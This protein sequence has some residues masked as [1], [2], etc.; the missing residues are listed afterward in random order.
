MPEGPSV[1]ALPGKGKSFEQFRYDDTECRSFA[2]EQTGATTAKDA[3]IESGF[4][5]AVIGAA[6]GAIAGFVLGGGEGAAVGAGT[7]FLAGGL[8]GTDNA[9][10]SGF[11]HQQRYDQGYIQCMYAKGHTVPV[12]GEFRNYPNDNNR[13]FSNPPPP[14]GYQPYPMYQ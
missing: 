11:I 10:A 14:P 8:S 1:M 7:G 6:L 13:T 5:S 2:Y 3:S 4:N 9:R 12:Q